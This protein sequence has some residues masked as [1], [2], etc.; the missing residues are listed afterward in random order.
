MSPIIKKFKNL[1]ELENEI[2]RLKL[3]AKKMEGEFDDHYLHLQKNYLPMLLNS[4]LPEKTSYKGIPA[5]IISL[6]LD[7][8]R[9]RN[10][11]IKLT[12]ELIDRLSDGIDYLSEKMKRKKDGTF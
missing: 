4:V 2:R 3:H 11:I 8:D 12:E 10:T 7:N 9:L 1:R 5:T 6:L